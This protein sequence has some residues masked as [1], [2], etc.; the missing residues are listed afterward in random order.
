MGA[1]FTMGTNFMG[2]FFRGKF[3][4]VI[5]R[6]QIS[7]GNSY[8]LSKSKIKIIWEQSYICQMSLSLISEGKLPGGPRGQIPEG[9]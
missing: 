6:V 5:F 7:W 8:S 1:K 3:H 2:Q 4:G 9:K